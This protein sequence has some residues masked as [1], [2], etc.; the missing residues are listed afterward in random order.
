MQGRKPTAS[1]T[2]RCSGIRS[3]GERTDMHRQPHEVAAAAGAV[4]VV[5][6]VTPCALFRGRWSGTAGQ[7]DSRA[8]MSRTK[9]NEREPANANHRSSSRPLGC[10]RTRS[11]TVRVSALAPS[12]T[13]PRTCGPH[14]VAARAGEARSAPFHAAAPR[15][16]GPAALPSSAAAMIAS[17]AALIARSVSRLQ[18]RAGLAPADFGALAPGSHGAAPGFRLSHL[19]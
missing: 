10:S 16:R 15:S 7:A 12:P 19:E 11:M 2:S 14:R 17:N 13:Y 9:A 6:T 5:R 18:S 3:L 4:Q 8:E 1:G